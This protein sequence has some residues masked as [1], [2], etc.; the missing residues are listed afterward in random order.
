VQAHAR[1]SE[2]QELKPPTEICQQR[3]RRK[4]RDINQLVERVGGPIFHWKRKVFNAAHKCTIPPV[5]VIGFDSE[6]I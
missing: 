6:P 1:K 5:I 4:P 3:W 2:A